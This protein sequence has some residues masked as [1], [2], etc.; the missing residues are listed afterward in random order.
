M[1]SMDHKAYSSTI[2]YV[3][4]ILMILTAVKNGLVIMDEYIVKHY[5]W[6]H[7]LKICG[8]SLVRILVLYM[9]Q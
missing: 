2:K 1:N 7:V 5:V 4:T 3:S 9:V 6:P 8:P